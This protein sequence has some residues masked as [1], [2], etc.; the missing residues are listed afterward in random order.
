[1]P[2][3]LAVKNPLLID[4]AEL[5]QLLCDHGADINAT[6]KV[7]KQSDTLNSERQRTLQNMTDPSISVH[8]KVLDEEPTPGLKLPLL[9]LF[10]LFRG[11]TC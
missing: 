2:L 5:F 10:H 3:H 4:H 9:S 6:N 8:A 7:V 1:M 11:K